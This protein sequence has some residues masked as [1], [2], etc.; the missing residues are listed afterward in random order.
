[1]RISSGVIAT[2]PAIS[3]HYLV[4]LPAL[5]EPVALPPGRSVRLERVHQ[6]EDEPVP[7]RFLHFH[8]PAELVFME[9]GSGSFITEAGE[10]VFAS[11]S[12]LYAPGMAIHDF[13]F[14]PGVRRWTLVQFDPLAVDP[15]IPALP[16]AARAATPDSLVSQRVSLLLAWLA[17][18]LE[19]HLPEPQVIVL[20]EA[21]LLALRGVFGE[22]A[23]VD[24]AQSSGL[25]HFR[26]L[27]QH[28]E[29][30]PGKALSLAEAASLCALSASYFSRLFARTFGA[31]FVTYQ[32]RFRLQQA[33]RMLATGDM[34]VSQI[35]YRTGFHSHAYF[36]QCYRSVFGVSPS[37]HRK[38]LLAG[39]QT[40]E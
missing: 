5:S 14:A 8:G 7:E 1:M 16:A 28:W 2:I 21:L 24:G 26:P 34:P 10:C 31:S 19:E 3:Y 13:A 25:S 23:G 33:A 32:T 12:V 20:L 38:M 36:S 35:G 9:Q 17:A 39:R 4:M 11:G 15:R 6:A 29:R 22:A 30:Y 27:L 37:E 18:S 40:K